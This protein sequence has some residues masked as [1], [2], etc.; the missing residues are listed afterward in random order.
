LNKPNPVSSLQMAELAAGAADEKSA[1]DIVLID[2]QSRLS[3]TDYFVVATAANP[4]QVR[5]RREGTN[6]GKWVLLDFT[7]VIVHIQDAEAREYYDLPRLWRDCPMQPFA[8]VA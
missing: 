8:R 6:E 3:L 1:T 2:V 5:A 7:D 4:R